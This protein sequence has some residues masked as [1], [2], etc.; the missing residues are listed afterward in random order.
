ME[1]FYCVVGGVCYN[2]YSCRGM[3]RLFCFYG[4]V[5]GMAVSV[6]LIGPEMIINHKIDDWSY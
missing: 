2:L 1:G 3:G 4:L 6:C 5:Y